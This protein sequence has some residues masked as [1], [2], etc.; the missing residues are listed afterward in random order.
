M[1]LP[2]LYNAYHAHCEAL[3]IDLIVWVDT[4]VAKD[5]LDLPLK[6]MVDATMHAAPR[7][8]V[9]GAAPQLGFKDIF[10]N[11]QFSIHE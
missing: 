3:D 7:L 6:V 4:K 10:G 9:I 2:M 5:K 8:L 11:S 1:K